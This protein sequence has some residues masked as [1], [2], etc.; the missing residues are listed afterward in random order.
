MTMRMRLFQSMRFALECF[1]FAL[2]L[3]GIWKWAGLPC[4]IWAVWLVAVLSMLGAFALTWLGERVAR[5]ELKELVEAVCADAERDEGACT[6]LPRRCAPRNDKYG[7]R[8]ETEVPAHTSSAP[9][10][11]LPLK[12]KALR[13]H[14]QVRHYGAMMG[15]RA[16]MGA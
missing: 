14:T 12:G 1:G 3:A 4:E 16:R 8:S 6:R 13:A 7:V 15:A 11:H 10:G 5:R 9:S 2:V